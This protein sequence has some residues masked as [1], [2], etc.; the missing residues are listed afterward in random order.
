M[1][2]RTGAAVGP[3]SR[4]LAGL[5]WL[6]AAFLLAYLRLPPLPDV[7]WWGFPAPTVLVIGG[8][9]AGLLVAALARIGVVIGARRRARLAR[10]R[11]LAAVTRVS[12]EQCSPPSGPS[13][14]ATRP[15]APPSPAPGAELRP[16]SP[17]GLYRFACRVVPGSRCPLGS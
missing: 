4:V 7:L 10:Q 1:E 15:P 9:V 6:G 16:S 12:Q 3:R 17:A 5:G 2:R 14:S 13:C 11:L 8:V